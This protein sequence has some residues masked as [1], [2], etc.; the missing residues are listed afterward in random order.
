[1]DKVTGTDIAIHPTN[2]KGVG[3]LTTI[4]LGQIKNYLLEAQTQLLIGQREVSR[5]PNKDLLYGFQR[6][7]FPNTKLSLNVGVKMTVVTGI[8]VPI[9]TWRAGCVPNY[10]SI[11]RRPQRNSILRVVPK[12]VRDAVGKYYEFT[13]KRR[14]QD[15]KKNKRRREDLSLVDKNKIR[16]SG[17]RR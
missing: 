13:M 4:G 10:T 16:S 3:C 11:L 8:T 1:M 14:Y 12:G 15:G 6:L 2:L 7:H 17:A 9:Q 5:T